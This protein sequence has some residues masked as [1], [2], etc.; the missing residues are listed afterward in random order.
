MKISVKLAIIPIV[1]LLLT[2]AV[3]VCKAASDRVVIVPKPDPSLIEYQFSEG[4]SAEPVS[5]A[6]VR[7][8]GNKPTYIFYQ[9]YTKGTQYRAL[10]LPRMKLSSAGPLSASD[11]GSVSEKKLRD[12]P[13]TALSLDLCDSSGT[14]TRDKTIIS[15]IPNAIP[16]TILGY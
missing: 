11:E 9:D 4:H 16:K 6:S 10:D 8:T 5:R 2:A 14:P 15:Q 12:D 7:C 3:S 13:Q 1:G